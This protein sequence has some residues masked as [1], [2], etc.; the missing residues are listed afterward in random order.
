MS[1]RR[2]PAPEGRPS[3]LADIGIGLAEPA[4][5]DEATFRHWPSTVRRRPGAA[6]SACGLASRDAAAPESGAVIVSRARK[7]R[8]AA[9]RVVAGVVGPAAAGSRRARRAQPVRHRRSLT[10]GWPASTAPPGL[11]AP[12]LHARPR[13]PGRTPRGPRTIRPRTPSDD[14]S[15]AASGSRASAWPRQARCAAG[16]HIPQT[17]P[18]TRSCAARGADWSAEQAAAQGVTSPTAVIAHAVPGFHASRASLVRSRSDSRRR[19]CRCRDLARDVVPHAS[20]DLRA[21]QQPG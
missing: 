1:L 9:D 5:D 6:R 17:R 13:R 12:L 7:T 10:A 14:H 18:D 19:G 8:A 11:S 3:P 21:L 16:V 2:S 4:A 15:V 20:C